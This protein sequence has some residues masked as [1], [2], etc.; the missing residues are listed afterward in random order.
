MIND[1]LKI[2]EKYDLFSEKIDDFYFWHYIRFGIYREIERQVGYIDVQVNSNKKRKVISRLKKIVVDSLHRCKEKKDVVFTCLINHT[3]KKDIYSDIY[4]EQ[5]TKSLK[6][7]F[8]VIEQKPAH[9][10]KDEYGIDNVYSVLDLDVYISLYKRIVKK[11]IFFT[12]SEKL[13]N[14]INEI[15]DKYSCDITYEMLKE[16][17]TNC[18]IRRKFGRRY[19][20]KAFKTIKPKVIVEVDGYYIDNMII[21][22]IAKD[23]QI[24]TIELQHGI[25]GDGHL[26]YNFSKK[27]NLHTFPDYIFTYSDFWNNTTRFP[28]ADEK[29]IATGFPHLEKIVEKSKMSNVKTDENSNKKNILVISQWTAAKTLSEF[30]V[31]LYDHLKKTYDGE[32][33]ISYKLHPADNLNNEE[34]FGK[35]NECSDKIKIIRHDEKSLYD[36]FLESDIQIG[37]SSTGI[38]EGLA[39]GLKTFLV[40][41]G[42]SERMQSLVDE[43]YAKY[44]ECPEDIDISKSNTSNI[45]VGNFWK[46][47]ALNNILENIDII[48]KEE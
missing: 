28:I 40:K 43:G 36:C 41:A 24:P 9:F 3:I 45:K 37:A 44:V 42:G 5:I 14:A 12:P 7:S 17:I 22:E 8:L 20:K 30:A 2:E 4:V 25:M 48:M 39:F 34:S 13:K 32:F 1:F 46:D 19:F 47:N 29:V 18:Y 21:N 38:Y 35:L 6:N 27:Q 15:N 33:L 26:A 10:G 16:R 23:M 11:P 31:G